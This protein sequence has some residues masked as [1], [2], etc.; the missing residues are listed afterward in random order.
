MI[1]PDYLAQFDGLMMMTNGNLPLE[2]S[3]KK[4]L[5][6]FV[7]NGGGFIGVH[8]ASLTLY[9]YPEFGEMLGAYFRRTVSQNHI[10]V[11]TVED[12]DHPAT[13]ML[14]ASWPIVDEFYQFG[15]SSWH[16][17]RPEENVDILFG[18]RI[19]IGFSRNRVRVLLSIDTEATDISGL[20]EIELGDDYPQ[21]WVQDFGKGR[22]F[23]TSLGHRD[24]IWSNDPVFRTHLIGGIR[25][26]LGLEDGDATPLGR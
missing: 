15:T 1:T 12:L 17:D 19:P 20:E 26:A 21:S 3:Q 14:G 9:N 11:L 4:A 25:W 7:R 10:V 6:D 5:I 23:Y 18:N 24:D 16:E 13:K 22:S 2:D 8:N